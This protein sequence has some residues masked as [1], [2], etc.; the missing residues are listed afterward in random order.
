MKYLCI[1]IQQDT[2]FIPFTEY[3]FLVPHYSTR[4][5]ECAITS[6]TPEMM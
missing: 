6:C 4:F 1:Q 5:H 2:K 3:V